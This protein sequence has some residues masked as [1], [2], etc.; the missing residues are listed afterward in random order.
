MRLSRMRKMPAHLGN[1]S[2]RAPGR[3]ASHPAAYSLKQIWS[4]RHETAASDGDD[5]ERL[6]TTFEDLSEGT[7]RLFQKSR[8]DVRSGHVA[9]AKRECE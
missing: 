2:G 1:E 7:E 8:V 4:K 9:F 6:S 3:E 5:L